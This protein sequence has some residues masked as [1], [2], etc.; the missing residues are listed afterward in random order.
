MARAPDIVLL[1]LMLPGIDGL[2]VCRK[3]RSNPATQT[4]PVIMITALGGEEDVIEGLEIGAD[5]YLAKPFS[6]RVLTA[7]VHA[8]MRRGRAEE[9]PALLTTGR[10]WKKSWPGR[11]I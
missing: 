6:P 4:L 7:R 10:P 3:L 11:L 8:V 1:D 9:T 2:S 5:D